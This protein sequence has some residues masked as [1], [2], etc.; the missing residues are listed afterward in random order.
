MNT[1]VETT[2]LISQYH[3]D[4]TNLHK[5]GPFISDDRISKVLFFN[6][7]S[8]RFKIIT[9]MFLIMYFVF[10]ICMYVYVLDHTLAKSK[11]YF[12]FYLLFFPLINLLLIF[13]L[14]RYILSAILYPY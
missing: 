7:Q 5:H 14:G 3:K 4:T 12:Y 1:K 8:T 11:L 2:N 13:G 10:V 9:T 6:L